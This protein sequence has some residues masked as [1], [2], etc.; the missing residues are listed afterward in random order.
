MLRTRLR[1]ARFK[2]VLKARVNGTVSLYFV[3]L[4]IL[5]SFTQNYTA[6]LLYY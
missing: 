3:I 6:V 5:C 1:L 2:A 4:Y